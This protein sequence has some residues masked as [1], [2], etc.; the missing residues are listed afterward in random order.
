MK[1]TPKVAAGGAAGAVTVVLVW[2]AGMFDIAVPPEVAS[3]A[4]VL[5]SSG[6]SYWKKGS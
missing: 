6:V 2:V 5:I 1:P 3:A 4:T